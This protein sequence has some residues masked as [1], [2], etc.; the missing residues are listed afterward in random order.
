VL[1]RAV[2][3]KRRGRRL[4][5]VFAI[6]SLV[7]GTLLAAGTA[8]AVPG[9]GSIFELDA[10]ADLSNGSA[11]KAAVTDNATAGL[12]DD[13][14]RIASDFNLDNNNAPGSNAD[15]SSFDAETT[16]T[17]TADART[18]FTGGGSKDQQ[19]LN[20]WASKDQLGGLPDKDNL[21]HAMSARYNN[22]NGGNDYVFFGADRYD[23]SGDAQIGF[24]FFKKTVCVKPDG[25]FGNTL[26]GTVCSGTAV[27]S[28]GEVPH[29]TTDPTKQGDILILSDFTNGG[30]QPT[31]RIFEYTGTAVGSTDGTL[32]EIGG[33]DAENRDCAVISTDDFCASVN[34]L[35]GA[36]AP[37]LFKNKSGQA[38][39]G[40]GEFY[41]GGLNLNTLG[42]ENECFSSFLAE[43]RSSQSVTATLKD[44]ILGG[45]EACEAT[46]TTTPTN[47][48]TTTDVNSITL[49]GDIYDHAVIVGTGSN[50]NPTGTMNFYLCSPAQMTALNETTCVTGG[51]EINGPTIPNKVTVTPIA[52]TS[53][54]EATSSK[55]TPNAVGT[56]CWRGEYSGDNRY[57]PAKDSST[58]ECFTVTDIAST[59]TQQSWLPQD[60]ATITSSGGSAIA[61]SVEFKLYESADCTGTAV[62]TFS[63]RPVS[64]TAPYIATTN[65]STYYSTATTIS[66]KATF[67]SSNGVASGSAAPCETMTVTLDN[68]ITAP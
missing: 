65:N 49:G 29:N 53:N 34:N 63:N 43:T 15:A 27:H 19:P 24:W 3:K 67:T 40:H 45:F 31:I 2:Y 35:D 51:T 48:T 47:G 59:T 22:V 14:D 38:T 42:L 64:A 7:T 33:G 10:S 66:W 18:I 37:W 20:K 50:Q 1:S 41:E 28:A 8:L 13:W 62:Q 60:Q 57:P 21:L 36:V 4:L 26:T 6:T 39:F 25:S 44:F 32:N 23:N 5:T 46:V 12:P 30:V 55:A 16:A 52:N 54:S 58:G 61:G 56:W 68:D 9:G 11:P 17:G